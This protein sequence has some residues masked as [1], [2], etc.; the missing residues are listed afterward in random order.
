MSEENYA[1]IAK[2]LSSSIKYLMKYPKTKRIK[3]QRKGN[4][5]KITK[6]KNKHFDHIFQFVFSFHQA[7]S[8]EEVSYARKR[9]KQHGTVLT[10]FKQNSDISFFIST[11]KKGQGKS[12]TK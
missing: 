8:N 7:P 5:K 2:T 10:S 12:A 6:S 3:L 4:L 11:G 1:T 9:L